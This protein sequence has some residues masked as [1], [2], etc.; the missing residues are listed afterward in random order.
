MNKLQIQSS[1]RR[2][3]KA[4]DVAMSHT[5]GGAGNDGGRE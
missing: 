2:N 4:N 5:C 3:S 1:V